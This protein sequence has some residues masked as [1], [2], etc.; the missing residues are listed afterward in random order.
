MISLEFLLASA[1]GYLLRQAFIY[2]R[3]YL[4]CCVGL[5]RLVMQLTYFCLR[6]VVYKSA[7]LQS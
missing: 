3:A 1:I 4:P 5:S 6:W 2:L 7:H